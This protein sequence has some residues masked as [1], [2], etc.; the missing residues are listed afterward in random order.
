MVLT[1]IQVS[2]ECYIGISMPYKKK[3]RSCKA[4]V[5]GQDIGTGLEK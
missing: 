3:Q 5:D 2:F 4:T 1:W